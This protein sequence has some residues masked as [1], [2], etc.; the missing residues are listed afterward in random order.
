MAGECLASIAASIEP[1]FPQRLSV[2]PSSA[3]YHCHGFAQD[4]HIQPVRPVIDILQVER[5][6]FVEVLDAISSADFPSAGETG[7]DA[8]AAALRVLLDGF[9]L[10][11]WQR[12]WADEVHLATQHVG[13][14]RQLR[15]FVDAEFAQE[16]AEREDARVVAD[17]EDGDLNRDH[18]A[19]RHFPAEK[20]TM[21]PTIVPIQTRVL[22]SSR[23][24]CTGLLC[25]RWL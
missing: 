1:L 11:H 6:P 24:H 23:R 22:A 17:L 12:A 9:D 13:Q 20:T 18:G 19:A 15:Q 5:D 3:H 8:Q 7:F 2:R 16:L 14:L 25:S 21:A 4:Y 10:L